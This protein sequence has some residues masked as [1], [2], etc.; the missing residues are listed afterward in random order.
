MN[1][2]V[3][4]RSPSAQGRGR[5]EAFRLARRRFLDGRRIDMQE[6]AAELGVD[7]TTLFRWVGNRDVLVVDILISLADPTLAHIEESLSETGGARIIQAA[8]SYA[9]ALI[10][11]DYYR[12]FLRREPQRALRLIT[13]KASPL[14]QRVVAS[15]DRIIRL[16]M[17]RGRLRHPLSSHD[18]AYLVVRIIESFIYADLIIGDPPDASKVNSAIS[19]LVSERSDERTPS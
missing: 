1:L 2:A 3:P 5:E 11:A 19:G 17:D 13:T 16:E 15:F 9:E 8:T 6:L 10:A 12:E 18:L 7:R 14:Q 4:S